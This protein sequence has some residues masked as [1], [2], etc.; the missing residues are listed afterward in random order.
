MRWERRL[1]ENG[2]KMLLENTLKQGIYVDK[3]IFLCYN[4]I[5]GGKSEKILSAEE[6]GLSE[7]GLQKINLKDNSI[8]LV[9]KPYAIKTLKISFNTK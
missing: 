2:R 3:L 7:E 5:D 9:V 8:Q 1:T 4:N 6:A